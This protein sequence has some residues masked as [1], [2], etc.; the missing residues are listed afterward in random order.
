MVAP[1]A[2]VM[3]GIWQHNVVATRL[4]SAEAAEELLNYWRQK[5]LLFKYMIIPI[6]GYRGVATEKDVEAL[7]K[8]IP[9]FSLTACEKAK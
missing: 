1:A 9:I 2:R 4:E 7:A 3:V 5:P 8:Q 6:L